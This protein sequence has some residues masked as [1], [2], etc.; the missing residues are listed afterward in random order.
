MRD[1]IEKI[2]YYGKGRLE[3]K[4]KYADELQELVNEIGGLSDGDGE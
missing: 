4:L 2:V 3:I 1:L